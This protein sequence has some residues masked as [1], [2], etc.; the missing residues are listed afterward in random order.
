MA[1]SGKIFV[2]AAAV[3]LLCLLAS[4]CEQ[5]AGRAAGPDVPRG[6]VSQIRVEQQDRVLSFGPFVGYYFR[7]EAR[8]DFTRLQFVCFNE[9]NFYTDDLP[10][11]AKLFEGTAVLTRLPDVDFSLP[12]SG[13]I[14]P[15]YFPEAPARWTAA[16]PEPGDAFLHFHSCYDTQG[17]VLTG[18]WFRH[19][20]VAAFTYDMGG[21][22]GPQSPLYHEVVPGTDKDFARIIEFDSGPE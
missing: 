15:V 3:A 20:A 1:Q 5:S 12:D 9:Q 8:G 4:G 16:R 17:P 6:Y 13:R 7:P 11:N 21:R 10:E 22:V 19:E 2:S 18:Y 14:N